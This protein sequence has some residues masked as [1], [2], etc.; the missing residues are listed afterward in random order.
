M[1]RRVC[2]L[3]IL[4]VLASLLTGVTQV[5]PGERAVVRRFGRVVAT[6]GAGLRVGLPWGLETVER[7]AVDRVRRVTVGYLPE[8][9]EAGD[10]APPGQL[11]TGDQNLVNVQAVID[12][13]VRADAVAD[14]A[15]AADRVDGALS[16]AAEAAVAEWVAGR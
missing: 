12:Y 1:M 3:L 14:Y 8:V 10:D 13:A 4:A 11:L 15:A 9:E 5:R 2:V 16:R 6:P 7:V